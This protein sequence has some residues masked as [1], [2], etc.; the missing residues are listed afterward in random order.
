MLM[1]WNNRK[2]YDPVI[3]PYDLIGFFLGMNE[4]DIA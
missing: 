1:N 2:A 3:V 4:G